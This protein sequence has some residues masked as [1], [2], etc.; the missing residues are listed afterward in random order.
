MCTESEV[1][2]TVHQGDAELEVQHKGVC[3][4][5]RWPV[6]RRDVARHVPQA[7]AHELH[8]GIAR[9]HDHEE[10]AADDEQDVQEEVDIR[11]HRVVPQRD[12]DPRH[13]LAVAAVA[14]HK[15]EQAVAQGDNKLCDLHGK[16][17]V[18]L[19]PRRGKNLLASGTRETPQRACR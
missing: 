16:R 10:V 11:W 19:F 14:A 8:Q 3:E 7:G 18:G 15:E 2:P 1:H 4:Q 9:D 17:G 12:P 13:P 5:D 6:D